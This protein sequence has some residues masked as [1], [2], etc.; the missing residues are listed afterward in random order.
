MKV[1]P[2]SGNVLDGQWIDGSAPV[3]TAIALAAGKVWIT[4]DTAAADVPF[5]PGVLAPPNL[6]TGF[7][8]GAFLSAVH[9]SGGVDTGPRIA[10]GPG[11][12]H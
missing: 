8:P 1:G 4:G 11:W 2:D 6:G 7:Q 9:F 5:S 12:R 10:C 3:S